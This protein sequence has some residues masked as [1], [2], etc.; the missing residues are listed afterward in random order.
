MKGSF[1]T[2]L[3]TEIAKSIV[4]ELRSQQLRGRHVQSL[5]LTSRVQFREFSHFVEVGPYFSGKQSKFGDFLWPIHSISE[6]R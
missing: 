3:G 4:R 2:S 5:G 1:G 6:G